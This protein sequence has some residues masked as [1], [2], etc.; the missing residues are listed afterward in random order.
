MIFNHLIDI[1]KESTPIVRLLGV[2]LENF[3]STAA[4]TITMPSLFKKQYTVTSGEILGLY[5]Q[6]GTGKSAVV[7]ALVV[8]VWA[9]TSEYQ[10]QVRKSSEKTSSDLSPIKGECQ[11]D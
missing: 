3:K 10:I 8:L 5:G 4:G 6:N 9:Y 2:R 7:E 11:T 1:M